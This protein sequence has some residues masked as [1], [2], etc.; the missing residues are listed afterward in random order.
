LLLNHGINV[1]NT[2][3]DG[4]TPLRSAASN[5]HLEVPGQLLSNGGILHIA[6]KLELAALL[7]A[8]DS[9]Q[10]EALRE[11]LKYRACVVIEINKMFRNSKRSS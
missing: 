1:D 3:N 9:D 6:R 4:Q 8:A 2:D 5:V 11:F 7:A 10:L